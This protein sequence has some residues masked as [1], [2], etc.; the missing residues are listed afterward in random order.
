[1]KSL[2]RSYIGSLEWMVIW[3]AE[4]V[5]SIDTEQPTILSIDS[6]G[7]PTMS[8]REATCRFCGTI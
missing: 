2:A 8:V 6:M 5:M 1:M 4:C 7:V 3:K